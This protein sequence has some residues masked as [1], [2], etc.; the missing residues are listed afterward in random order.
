MRDEQRGQMTPV[1]VVN[2]VVVIVLM[3]ATSPAWLELSAYIA[4]PAGPLTSL[5]LQLFIPMMFLMI[6]LGASA[7]ARRRLA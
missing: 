1:D 2:I 3:I 5:I 4:E 7:S 6:L